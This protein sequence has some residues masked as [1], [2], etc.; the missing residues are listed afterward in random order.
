MLIEVNHSELATI[1][2]ALRLYVNEGCGDPMNRDDEIH[3]IATDDGP[4]ISLDDDGIEDL[5][6]RLIAVLENMDS[7]APATP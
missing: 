3:D 2:A 4:A 5:D 7:A 1:R 6:A